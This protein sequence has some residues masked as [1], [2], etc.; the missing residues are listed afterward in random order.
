MKTENEAF[1][2]A[3]LDAK[4]LFYHSKNLD[5]RDPTINV[6]GIGGFKYIP[7]EKDPK[8][9]PKGNLYVAGQRRHFDKEEWNTVENFSI[10]VWSNDV[11]RKDR[12]RGIVNW[13]EL[14]NEV[15][16]KIVK[17]ANIKDLTKAM[18]TME[19]LWSSDLP[20]YTPGYGIIEAI[21]K[22]LKEENVKLDFGE[23]HLAH[24]LVVSKSVEGDF[25]QAGF[26]IC[27]SFFADLGMKTSERAYSL[28]IKT[29]EVELTQKDQRRV[30]ILYEAVRG[31]GRGPRD[32]QVVKEKRIIRNLF[33]LTHRGSHKNVMLP[34]NIE[35]RALREGF[36]EC[37][38]TYL[39]EMDHDYGTDG[40]REFS[41]ALTDTI[42][43]VV[44][45]IISN[46]QVFI[47]LK[48]RWDEK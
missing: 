45:K 31:F 14:R 25:A 47:A 10:W 40:Q 16:P 36:A 7:S 33:M 23:K 1:A 34:V 32:I 28:M 15:V 38:G 48:K 9:K 4:E 30:E 27:H 3:F 2:K 26:K 44:E 41:D 29:K 17:A 22:R 5:F 37:L 11:L 42:K 39:H 20:S 6:T 8:T 19:D 35:I 13:I 46:P 24:N 18:Y 12:D 43:L 21:V